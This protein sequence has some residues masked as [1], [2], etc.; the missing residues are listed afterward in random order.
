MLA[1]H[2]AFPMLSWT[3]TITV[4]MS[5]HIQIVAPLTE[6]L[7]TLM[8]RYMTCEIAAMQL[9][10]EVRLL[11][12]FGGGQRGDPPVPLAGRASIATPF[13]SPLVNHPEHPE[14]GA[15]VDTSEVAR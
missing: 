12:W 8:A 11:R 5:R 9:E 2:L 3:A 14:F 6:F 13:Y 7:L 15:A 10:Q 1:A 4:P